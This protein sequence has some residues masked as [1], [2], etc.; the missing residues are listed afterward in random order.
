MACVAARA[1]S[2]GTRRQRGAEEHKG[3]EEQSIG[4]EYEKVTAAR[5]VNSFFKETRV[6]VRETLSRAPQSPQKVSLDV[7][8]GNPVYDTG[9][10]V[11]KSYELC[12]ELWVRK[13][14]T[15]VRACRANHRTRQRASSS[16]P[17]ETTAQSMTRG[18]R[19]TGHTPWVPD[20][21]CGKSEPPHAPIVRLLGAT[22]E[23]R[24]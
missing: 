19:P 14:Q 9:A 18:P 20:P 5:G 24:R 1:Q 11:H 3:R 4:R 22:T 2:R 8:Q 7:H 16:P 15:V 21:G 13:K 10:W 17:Q 12:A 23:H 6:L